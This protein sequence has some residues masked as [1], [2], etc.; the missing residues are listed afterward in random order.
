MQDF[1][2]HLDQS[3]IKKS[4]GAKIQATPVYRDP[5]PHTIIRDFFP[6]EFYRLVVS[7][8]PPRESFRPDDRLQRYD[9]VLKHDGGLWSIVLD[10]A[11]HASFAFFNKFRPYLDLKFS[12]YTDAFSL[13]DV[14]E[15]AFMFRGAQLSSYSGNFEMTPHVDHVLLVTNAFLYCNETGREESDLGLSLYKGLGLA[16]PTNWMLPKQALARAL[17]RRKK[18]PYGRNFCFAYLNTPHS[19]HGVDNVDI[20]TRERRVFMFGILMKPDK[21]RELVG[22]GLVP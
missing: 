5:F 12:P 21:C 19:I 15:H 8:W 22:R 1:P 11:H 2:A 7:N 17:V 4:V 9:Y 16:L 18:V 13:S 6:E 3:S 20:G 10:I 14:D